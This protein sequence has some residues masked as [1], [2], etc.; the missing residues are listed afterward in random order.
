M[1]CPCVFSS[2]ID[3]LSDCASANCT[4]FFGLGHRLYLAFVL[5][6]VSPCSAF[7]SSLL[8]AFISDVIFMS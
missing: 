5:I 2:T 1:T 4:V 7:S 3:C 6:S 8:L